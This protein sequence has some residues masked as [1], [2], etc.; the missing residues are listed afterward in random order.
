MHICISAGDG[1]T[2]ESLLPTATVR[3]HVSSHQTDARA[4]L[5]GLRPAAGKWHGRESD[6]TPADRHPGRR[7]VCA[8]ARS[9][10]RPARQFV[11][12]DK[13]RC[14]SPPIWASLACK[15][16]VKLGRAGP[17]LLIFPRRKTPTPAESASAGPIPPR[18]PSSRSRRR[19]PRQ[20]LVLFLAHTSLCSTR[21]SS[22]T[23]PPRRQDWEPA[24]RK[25]ARGLPQGLRE[26]LARAGDDTDG[27]LIQRCFG[28]LACWD[29]SFLFP[30]FSKYDRV[31]HFGPV[32]L[33]AL[34]CL[35]IGRRVSCVRN[36]ALIAFVLTQRCF[37]LAFVRE[38]RDGEAR[39]MLTTPAS[40]V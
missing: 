7:L 30:S 10:I 14:V 32:S 19:S 8:R 29:Y 38:S 11:P 36:S 28:V 18:S 17:W 15:L 4:R 31:G 12:E 40:G 23:C 33:I 24:R 2:R 25:C 27:Q 34:F 35:R 26:H 39:V 13:W 3:V 21:M 37:S 1:R 16:R 20:L 22:R 5:R 6:S 9:G